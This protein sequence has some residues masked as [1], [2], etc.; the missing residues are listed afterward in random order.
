ML[1]KGWGG[2]ETEVLPE[3]VYGLESVPHD[4]LFPRVAAVVHHGGAGTT[5]AGLRAGKPSVLCP[6]YGD[7]AFWARRIHALGAGPAPVPQKQLNADTLAAAIT[8]AVTDTT[9][10]EKACSLGKKFVPRMESR[11]LSNS[12]KDFHEP[13]PDL[14]E[15]SK[16]EPLE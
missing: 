12:F 9:M 5:A 4:W 6:F 15:S 11:R 7:Q 3:G 1:A 16:V 13:S 10:Q 2:L 14:L 8:A